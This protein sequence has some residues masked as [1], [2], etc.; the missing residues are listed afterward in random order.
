MMGMHTIVAVCQGAQRRGA[1]RTTPAVCQGVQRWG[2]IHIIPAVYQ[3]VHSLEN[4][5]M[6]KTVEIIISLVMEMAIIKG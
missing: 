6:G 2:T 3:A 1:I 4:T 5:A